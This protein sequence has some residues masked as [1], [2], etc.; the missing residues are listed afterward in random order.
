VDTP[1]IVQ[2]ASLRSD[3]EIIRLSQA[4]F[5]V[6]LWSTLPPPAKA[7]FVLEVEKLKVHG[8]AG[9]GG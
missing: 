5:S 3:R 2:S 6:N 7:K 9:G 1:E 4:S 8:G